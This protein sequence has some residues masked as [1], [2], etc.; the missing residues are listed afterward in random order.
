MHMNQSEL[1][2]IAIETAI[3]AGLGIMP[4]YQSDDFNIS[5]KEDKT[6][7]TKADLAANEIIS[8][9]LLKTNI[10]ILSEEGSITSFETRKTWK[11]LWIVDPIDGTKEFIKRNDEF[12]VN[13]A[14]IENGQPV[15]GVIYAPAL[16]TLYFASMITGTYKIED[17]DSYHSV[18]RLIELGQKLPLQNQLETFT[19][20]A[21]RSHPS[22]ETSMFIDAL[23]KKHGEVNTLSIGS[24]LKLCMIAEG[25][26]NVYPRFSPTMEWD[27]AAGHAICLFAKANVIDV[28]TEKQMTYNRENLTNNWF[29]AST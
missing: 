16:K 19:V 10:P 20:V 21:S 1:L 8:T 26:A 25:S 4:I 6:P 22:M 12:T 17:I 2:N 13:I 24:S 29:M 27:I 3:K 28:K 18:E 5:E 7:L 9:Q 23:R 11:K 14:L 15:I